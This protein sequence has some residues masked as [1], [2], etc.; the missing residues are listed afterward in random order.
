MKI[1]LTRI[2]PVITYASETWTLNEHDKS[3][4]CVYE[5]Q[6]LRKIFS[7]NE[8]RKMPGVYEVML[9]VIV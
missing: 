4:L 7:H 6:L 5:R 9:N 3:R 8:L 2:R 1:Y